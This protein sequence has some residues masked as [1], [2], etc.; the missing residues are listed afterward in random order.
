MANK[1]GPTRGELL[2]RAAFS[3]FGLLGIA[4]LLA[5]R[6]LPNGPGLVEVFGIALAFF[7][8][9]L[10]HAIWRLWRPIDQERG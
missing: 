4:L 7:A 2:F 5:V 6:G 10:G 8:G 1:Y 9:S 3:V